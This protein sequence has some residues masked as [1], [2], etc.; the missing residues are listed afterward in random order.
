MKPTCSL[1][2]GSTTID[3]GDSV[4]LTWSSTW[5]DSATL[6]GEPVDINNTLGYTVT[7]SLTTTYTFQSKGP[8]GTSPNCSMTITIRG[9]SRR[10]TCQPIFYQSLSNVVLKV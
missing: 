10:F 5:A 1:S 6:N 3:E 4:D 7:P 8:G 2:P 9:G